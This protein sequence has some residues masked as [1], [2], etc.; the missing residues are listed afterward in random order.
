MT[1]EHASLLLDAAGVDGEGAAPRLDALFGEHGTVHELDPDDRAAA[2][3][4]DLLAK[5]CFSGVSAER[6]GLLLDVLAD[7]WGLP[8]RAAGLPAVLA[9]D[10]DAGLSSVISD[11]EGRVKALPAPERSELRQ[12]ISRVTKGHRA[13]VGDIPA[14]RLAGF[15]QRLAEVESARRE[16]A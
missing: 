9:E 5:D 13:R 10:L 15:A 16:A 1:A 2:H 6:A 11:L 7:V 8:M 12:G 4:A 14:G 3:L